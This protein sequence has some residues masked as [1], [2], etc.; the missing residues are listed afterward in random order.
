MQ[1]KKKRG[2]RR[3]R[4]VLLVVGAERGESFEGAVQKCA[5]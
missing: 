2:R 1:R 4:V 5:E 3:R